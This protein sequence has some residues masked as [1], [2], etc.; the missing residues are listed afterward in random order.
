M[1]VEM[2]VRDFRQKVCAEVRLQEKGIGRFRVL[3]PFL[4]EDGDHL[5]IV[6]RQEAPGWVLSDEGHT[7]MHLTYDLDERDLYRG[8]R[9]KIITSALSVYGVSDRDGELVLP[10]GDEEYGNALYSFVQALLKITDVTYLSRE[11][12]RSTFLED[13]RAFLSETAPEDRRTFGWFDTARDPEGK[14]TVDCRINTMPKP[15]FVF[16]LPNDDRTMIAHITILQFEKWGLPFLSLGVFQD[17]EMINR[18]VLARFS[19]VCG[20]QFSNLGGNKDRISSYLAEAM[21]QGGR[22]A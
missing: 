11:L 15:L 9:Q 13:L 4:F 10:I 5:V 16:A 14:Y 17:Q 22:P 19:D 21:A 18:K 1:A 12:V 7:Y 20:K 2:I 3:T 6:L 8:T